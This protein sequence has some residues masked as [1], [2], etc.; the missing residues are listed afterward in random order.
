MQT[1][2]AYL[3]AQSAIVASPKPAE[4]VF[5]IIDQGHVDVNQYYP[6]GNTLVHM[7]AIAGRA[8]VMEG[9][10]ARGGRLDIKRNQSD[11]AT[12][13]ELAKRPEIVAYLT[14]IGA[15]KKPQPGSYKPAAAPVTKKP[16]AAASAAES[17][18][19]KMCNE[20]HYTSS[21]LCSDSTCKMREYRK[22]QTCLNTGSYY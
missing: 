18:R 20:R 12:P 4:E 3:D 19:R 11:A 5:R 8:D 15:M 2:D 7:A 6:D 14:R 1:G 13:V 16:A 21:A 22:W 9:L 10:L 17:P